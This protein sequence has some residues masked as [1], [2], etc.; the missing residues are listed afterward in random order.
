MATLFWHDYET[1]GTDPARDRPLQF[2]GVRT[3]ENLE[4]MGEPVQFHCRPDPL[5]LPH[6]AACLVTGISPQQAQRE[7]L[8]EP[9]FAARVIAELGAPGTCGVG[10]NSLRFDDEFTRFL[11]YR[12]FYD[13]YEREWRDGNSR[14]DIIDLLRVARALR[15]DGIRWPDHEDGG[16]SFRLE[17]LAAANG[18]AHGQAHDALSDVLATLDLA[19]LVRRRQPRLYRHLYEQRG[20]RHLLPLLDPAARRPVLHVSGRLPRERGYAGLLLPLARQPG[21]ANGIICFDLM[22]DARALVRLDAEAIR[23]L[24][25][26]PAAALPAGAERLPLKV[27]HLNRCPVVLTPKLLDAATARRLHIDLERCADHLRI[28]QGAELEAKLALVFAPPAASRPGVDAEAELYAGFLADAERPLLARVRAAAGHELDPAR[29]PFRDARYRELLF[30]YRARYFPETL[31]DAER[32]NWRE[33]CRWRL[34][35][36]HSGYLGLAAFRAE[37]VQLGTEPA[38]AARRHLLEALAEWG[39]RV[40]AALGIAAAG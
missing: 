31:S 15:P 20:R 17:D 27:I 32:D 38:G 22:G 16:P 37:L 6:P 2:A 29:I 7:G 25:F 4:P 33:F 10:Y 40:A 8:P 23:E 26:S 1:T 36:P 11:L 30:R 13:P 34:T 18:I 5:L 24:V 19:R 28:L 12:N 35:D 9:E 14:W 21:N 39:D 3:D